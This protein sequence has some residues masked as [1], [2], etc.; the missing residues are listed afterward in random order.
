MVVGTPFAKVVGD[1]VSVQLTGVGA[2]LADNVERLKIPR[3]ATEMPNSD[4]FIIRISL[5]N[6]A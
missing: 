6:L 1:A 4:F 3:T 2:A 5:N